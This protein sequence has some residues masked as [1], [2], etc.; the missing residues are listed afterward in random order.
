MYM[1]VVSDDPDVCLYLDPMPVDRNGE[2]DRGR[3]V[4]A[5]RDFG[6]LGLSNESLDDGAG[7]C[8]TNQQADVAHRFLSP[9]HAPGQRPAGLG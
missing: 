7:V 5:L 8:G 1:Y 3:R 9:A 2:D 4:R 6:H